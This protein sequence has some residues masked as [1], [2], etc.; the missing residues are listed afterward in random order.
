MRAFLITLCILAILYFCI[1][2]VVNSITKNENF[3]SHMPDSVL[4]LIIPIVVLICNA[5]LTIVPAQQCGVVIT[6][7][8]V[9]QETYNTGWHIIMPW[10]KVELMEKTAQVY[11]C[12]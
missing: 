8:G 2:K 7:S 12:A 10:Y 9:K 5:F 1:A 11:T 3:G 6:P 4:F